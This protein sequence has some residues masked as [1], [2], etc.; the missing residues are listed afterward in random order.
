MRATHQEEVPARGRE[1]SQ[2][3][4][5]AAGLCKSYGKTRALENV[6][7]EVLRGEVFGYLGPN[8]AGKTT[9][10]NI[11][12]GLLQ[13]DSGD[14]TLCGADVAR[15]PV[16]VKQQIGVVPE[17]SNLYPELSCRRNLEFL[18]ELYGMPRAARRRRAD[19][20]LQTFGLAEKGAAPFRTLSRGMK[21]R[22]TVAAALMHSPEVLLLDEPTAGLDVPSARAL[23]SLIKTF[24][25]DGTTVFLSTHNLAEA[26]SLCDRVLI[27]DKGRLVAIGTAAEVR[28]RVQ[29][30]KVISVVFSGNVTEH[31]LRSGCPAVL[32]ASCAEGRWRLEVNDIHSAL[33]QLVSLAEKEFVEVVEI[34]TA[35][36]TLEDAF[37]TLLAKN[38]PGGQ[39]C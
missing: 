8:G 11:F 34:A 37:V 35:I 24:N 27:L 19:E 17:E 21:R 3:V 26:E 18:G 33:A 28:Q 10:I 6:S 20:L 39:P 22:L 13:R 16:F 2:T 15:D 36:G 4:I 38:P 30:A 29:A 12:C 25:K 5:R 14:A 32:S 23:R 31:S 7:F 1:V 9:T